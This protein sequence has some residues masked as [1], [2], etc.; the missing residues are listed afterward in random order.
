MRIRLYAKVLQKKEGFSL[1]EVMITVVVVTLAL[2]G[3]LMA[4]SAIQQSGEASFE[5]AVAIQE[6]NQVIERMRQTAASGSFPSNVTTAFPNN[7]AR[8]NFT[9]LRPQCGALANPPSPCIWPFAFNSDGTSQEQVVVTYV[10]P[11]ANPLDVTVIV[12]WRER[13][14]RQAQ[15]SLRSLITQRS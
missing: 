11:N 1:I 13:G 12:V 6:A 10:N 4:N 2:V 7:T 9:S 15:I 5:R 8:P 14:I 3:T